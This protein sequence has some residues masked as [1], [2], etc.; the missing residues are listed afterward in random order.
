MV[1]VRVSLQGM[2]VSPCNVLKSD[3]NKL[4][5]EICT[6]YSV[7]S[8]WL[9]QWLTSAHLTQAA[10]RPAANTSSWNSTSTD[11]LA[12]KH[13]DKCT[14]TDACT[15]RQMHDWHTHRWGC[16]HTKGDT[17]G[18]NDFFFFLLQM[19]MSMLA[20]HILGGKQSHKQ[21]IFMQ[22]GC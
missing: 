19:G 22:K 18:R 6:L 17:K 15:H 3:G 13:A 21:N 20:L 4:Y 14:N 8:P 16:R 9:S 7:M 11:T 1:K 5:W 12:D 10:A 2:N